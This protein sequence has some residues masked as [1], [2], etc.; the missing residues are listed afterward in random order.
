MRRSGT[1]LNS[2]AWMGLALLGACGGKVPDLPSDR[3]WSSAHFDY[4]TREGDTSTCADVLDPLEQHF[5]QLQDYL[6]FVWPAGA[7]VTYYK[8]LD[9]GDFA[10]HADCPPDVG[11]CAP[12]TNVETSLGLDEHELVH[13]YLYPTGYPPWVILE[14]AAVA[15]S[16]QTRLLA[17]NKP[18]LTWDQLANVERGTPDVYD[19][20]AWLVGYL[21]DVYG[22]QKFMSLY[23]SLA[24]NASTSD[25]DAAFRQTFGQSLADVWASVLSEDHARNDCVWECSRAPLALDGGAIDSTA[26]CGQAYA[27]HPFMLASDATISFSSSSAGLMLGPCGAVSPPETWVVGNPGAIALYDL[28]AG[29]YFL[30]NDPVTGTIVASSDAS[31]TLTSVCASAIDGAALGLA[32]QENIY[33]LVPGSPSP[34]FLSLPPSDG[35]RVMVLASFEPAESAALCASCVPGS[36]TDASKLVSWSD[37]SV[38]MLT[39]DP[40]QPFSEF[41]PILQ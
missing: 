21:L 32:N 39:T 1:L 9:A 6:G 41:A 22:P 24:Q 26:T 17:S 4:R 38:L 31:K 18:T 3:Q 25:L 23:A 5:A 19:A 36:C 8:F 7:K 10:A 28:P 30:A 27:A 11:G 40:S 14:G 37:N 34:W 15:L 20:G 2:C 33:V 29:S 13:A 35:R 16:C 12:Q